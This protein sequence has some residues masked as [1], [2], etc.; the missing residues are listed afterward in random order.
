MQNRM[1]SRRRQGDTRPAQ[2]DKQQRV[3]RAPHERDESADSQ[4]A[5]D[6]SARSIGR[7]GRE[8]IERGVLD[9]D[10]GPVLDQVYDRVREDTDDPGRKFSP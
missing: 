3:P 2:G 8:D 6:P 1:T 7:A 5:E 4:A 10:K 9:T